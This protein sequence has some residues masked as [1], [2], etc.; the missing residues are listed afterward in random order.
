MGRRRITA[1]AIA[2]VTVAG[3]SGPEKRTTKPP[4]P[5]TTAPTATVRPPT[6]GPQPDPHRRPLPDGDWDYQ[7]GGVR[8]VR[9]D[10][11]IVV[12]DRRAPTAD[13]YDICYLNAFQTQ[14]AERAF[15]RREQNAWLVLRDRGRPVTD[16]PSALLLDT[17]GKKKRQRLTNIVARWMRRCA[18]AGAE[19]VELDNLDSWTRS[20][21]LLSRR[22]NTVYARKLVRRAHNIGLS[23]A[24]KNTPQLGLQAA[25]IGFD[26]AIVEECMRTRDC[27]AYA[28]VYD[29]D[30]L[31]VEYDRRR[32]RRSCASWGRTWAVIWRDRALTPDGPRA[33]C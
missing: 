21:G 17:R 19:A 16:G 23:V 8:P 7:L 30:V 18:A 25:L 6:Q 2:A 5:V 29:R 12:R 31:A 10:V 28:R 33:R 26:F 15:W 9:P 13:R 20:R 22:S 3:C 32:F 1:V 14:P 11:T 24:Q 4:S 27:R